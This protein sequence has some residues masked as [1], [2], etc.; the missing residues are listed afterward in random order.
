MKLCL[1]MKQNLRNEIWIYALKGER[2]K[3][4]T[5]YTF[6]FHILQSSLKHH[7]SSLFKSR[8]IHSLLIELQPIKFC[9]FH[10]NSVQISRWRNKHYKISEKNVAHT[11]QMT[12]SFQL[13][14]ERTNN[15][16]H[17]TTMR[18]NINP[19]HKSQHKSMKECKFI[20]S[21]TIY[22]VIQNTS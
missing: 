4:S 18:I 14:S 13:S 20:K 7:Q 6:H 10:L 15:G 21:S 17:L 3:K 5:F 19:T 16:F 8:F 12:P 11:V 22:I 2:V 9:R 1:R